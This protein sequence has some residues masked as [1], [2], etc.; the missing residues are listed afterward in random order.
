MNYLVFI[1][2]FDLDLLTWLG[3]EI[4]DVTRPSSSVVL[5]SALASSINLPPSG[6]LG[7]K[8]GLK[9]YPAS[10]E[11]WTLA[12][13]TNLLFHLESVALRNLKLHPVRSLS[14]LMS[15]PGE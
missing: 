15:S 12:T 8:F 1:V 7:Q 4:Y 10:K 14:N 13:L 11:V 3:T 6:S 2:I 5:D 9:I